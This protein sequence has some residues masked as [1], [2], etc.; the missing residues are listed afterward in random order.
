MPE[1]SHE[2]TLHST[3]TVWSEQPLGC[4]NVGSQHRD[5]RDHCLTLPD[6]CQ[7]MVW[8]QSQSGP[9]LAM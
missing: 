1:C 3:R 4:L 6:H 5:S 9:S 2:P 7:L 8:S